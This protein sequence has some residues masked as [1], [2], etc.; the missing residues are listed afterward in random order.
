MFVTSGLMMIRESSII[1][2]NEVR[3][4]LDLDNRS[5]LTGDMSSYAVCSENNHTN[6]NIIKYITLETNE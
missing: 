5:C 2:I 4:W 3:V 1:N 6:T